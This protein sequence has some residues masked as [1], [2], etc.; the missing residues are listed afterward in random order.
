MKYTVLL[1]VSLMFLY[2][3]IHCIGQ[4]KNTK[5]AT[6]FYNYMQN[7]KIGTRLRV[8]LKNEEKPIGRL[9]IKYTDH[10]EMAQD[11]YVTPYVIYYSDIKKMDSGYSKTEKLKFAVRLSYEIVYTTGFIFVYLVALAIYGS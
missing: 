5:D 9:T 1:M 6:Y 10:F 8:Q 2:F 3:P 7:K 11:N 4:N